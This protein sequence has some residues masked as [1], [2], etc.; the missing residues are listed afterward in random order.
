MIRIEI[1]N[2]L[3]GETL[4]GEIFVS[5]TIRRAK[6][7]LPKKNLSLSPDDNFNSTNKS[8]SVFT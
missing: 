1:S 4:M 8:E 3:A 6:F 2:T 5:K 7:S